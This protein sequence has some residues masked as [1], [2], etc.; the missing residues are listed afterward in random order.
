MHSALYSRILLLL[1]TVLP[2]LILFS[3]LSMQNLAIS[4]TRCILDCLQPLTHIYLRYNLMWRQVNSLA[5]RN[6]YICA[7]P[8]FWEGNPLKISI[9][10]PNTY[11][12]IGVYDFII[13]QFT[14]QGWFRGRWVAILPF[15]NLL[16]Y[17]APWSLEWP[18]PQP[19]PQWI[20][21]LHPQQWQ[22]GWA[23]GINTQP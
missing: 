16:P 20:H 19:L 18:L 15:W 5:D 23:N 7:G 9:T 14:I 6:P 11:L 22:R 8:D 10:F 3:V 4:Y 1:P 12:W 13:W 21:P 17:V 2:Q